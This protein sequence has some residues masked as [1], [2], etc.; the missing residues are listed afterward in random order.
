[1]TSYDI[2]FTMLLE[3]IECAGKCVQD[4]ANTPSY[5]FEKH[6]KTRDHWVKLFV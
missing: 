6:Y 3:D 2:Y 1:M 5:I 4:I